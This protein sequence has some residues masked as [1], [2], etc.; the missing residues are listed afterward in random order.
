MELKQAIELIKDPVIENNTKQV[1]TDLGCGTG[2]FTKALANL[3]AGESVIYAVDQNNTA[4][5]NIAPLD[6]V[7]MKSIQ[8]NFI[9]D[10]LGFQELNGILMANALHF[11][12]DKITLIKKLAGYCLPNHCFVIVEYDMETPNPWVPWPVSFA[13]L[14]Q[15][16][17]QCG[18]TSIKKKHEVPSIY[19]RSKIYSAIIKP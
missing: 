1:W 9:K 3:L 15:L 5:K 8:A 12:Q 2:L 19:N 13:S 7:L 11:V 14:Q 16:F 10:D 17:H 6:G 4:L 18:Y